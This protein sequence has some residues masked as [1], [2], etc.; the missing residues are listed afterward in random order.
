MQQVS[1]G[2]PFCCRAKRAFFHGYTTCWKR[3]L[4][5]WKPSGNFYPSLCWQ[6]HFRQNRCQEW[7]FPEGQWLLGQGGSVHLM[8]SPSSWDILKLSVEWQR[9]EIAGPETRTW[10]I[11]AICRDGPFDSE[12]SMCRCAHIWLLTHQAEVQQC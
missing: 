11:G 6:V 3:K 4:L 12:V 2:T 8:V 5:S 7:M 9:R 10:Q 1:I